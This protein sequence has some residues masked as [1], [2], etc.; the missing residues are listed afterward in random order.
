MHDK[1]G[2]LVVSLSKAMVLFQVTKKNEEYRVNQVLNSILS[3][4]LHEII[5]Q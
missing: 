1:K 5:R 3:Y 4:I 2:H